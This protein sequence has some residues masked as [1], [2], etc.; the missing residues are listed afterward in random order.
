MAAV[1]Y[2]DE[3]RMLRSDCMGAHADLNLRCPQNAYGSFF[4]RYALYA[5]KDAVW[6]KSHFG[7]N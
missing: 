1:L 6:E 2:V 4:L 7:I 5:I 3:Q